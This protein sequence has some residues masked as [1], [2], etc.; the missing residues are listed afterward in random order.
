MV[1]GNIPYLNN[2]SSYPRAFVI[3]FVLLILLRIG[4]YI[5]QKVFVKITS[6][7]KSDLDDIILEKSNK[8]LTYIA[9]LISLVVALQDISFESGVENIVFK[10]LYSLLELLLGI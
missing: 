3:F 7:T 4:L 2:L 1:F 5:V 10:I 6:K 9:L 8:P